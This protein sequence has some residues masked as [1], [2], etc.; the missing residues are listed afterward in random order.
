MKNPGRSGKKDRQDS[1]RRP[2]GP[3]G[4]GGGP[5]GPTPSKITFQNI[6]CRATIS[7]AIFFPTHPSL[8][9]CVTIIRI[10]FGTFNRLHPV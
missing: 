9:T 7:P 8:A 6:L 3:R 5:L 1:S 10:V 4:G 2:R